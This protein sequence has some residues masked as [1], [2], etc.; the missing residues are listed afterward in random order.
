MG[1]GR[2]GGRGRRE[3]GKGVVYAYEAYE[4]KK[5][6]GGIALSFA[7]PEN[8]KYYY[9]IYDV[10]TWEFFSKESRIYYYRGWPFSYISAI[11]FIL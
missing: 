10:I 5:R 4:A 3:R 8:E 1:G 6:G 11:A 2:G 7:S 9:S